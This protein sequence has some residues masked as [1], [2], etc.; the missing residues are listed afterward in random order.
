MASADDPAAAVLRVTR[1]E[2]ARVKRTREEIATAVSEGRLPQ[3][4]LV[5]IDELIELVRPLETSPR[6]RSESRC[7]PSPAPGR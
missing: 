5:L 7:H 4:N 2:I 1:E 3:E 6:R